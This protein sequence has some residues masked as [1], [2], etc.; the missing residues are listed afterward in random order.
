[1]IF[2]L[3]LTGAAD[4]TTDIELPVSN[5]TLR[6]RPSTQDSYLSVVIPNATAHADAITARSN[7]N[8][9]LAGDWSMIDCELTD[10]RI[11]RGPNSSSVTLTGYTAVTNASPQ[12][13]TLDEIQYLNLDPSGTTR[14]RAALQQIL[15]DDTV[16]YDTVSYTVE[17]ISISVNRNQTQM[18]LSC[19]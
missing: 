12:T 13:V 11:Q 3:T 1:M 14:L 5:F 15:P 2:T 16:I 10:I 9:Q 7:G 17:T 19:V 4:G 6:L 18:E 8:L